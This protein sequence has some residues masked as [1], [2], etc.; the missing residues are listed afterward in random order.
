[1]A[2]SSVWLSLIN[3]ASISYLT[4]SLRPVWI[5]CGVERLGW[6]VESPSDCFPKACFSAKPPPPRNTESKSSAPGLNCCFFVTLRKCCYQ[7]DLADDFV[8]W[9]FHVDTEHE[10]Q[11]INESEEM[12]FKYIRMAF[13]SFVHKINTIT[14]VSCSFLFSYMFPVGGGLGPPQGESSCPQHPS[15]VVGFFFFSSCI[16][17]PVSDLPPQL[18]MAIMLRVLL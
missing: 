16:F 18:W 1:M 12:H 13:L 15:Y 9:A 7:F 3:G 5:G 2:R 14:C 17:G 6:L 11:I 10:I 8:L 4:N